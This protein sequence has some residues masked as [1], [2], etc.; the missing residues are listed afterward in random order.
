MSLSGPQASRRC[1]TVVLGSAMTQE[2]TTD[3]NLRPPFSAASY[4]SSGYLNVGRPSARLR[5][6]VTLLA[7]TFQ[8]KFDSLLHVAL[9]FFTVRSGRNAARQVRRVGRK[10]RAGR[11]DDDEILHP[12][13]TFSSRLRTTRSLALFSL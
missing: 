10:T 12:C 2:E 1:L 4:P 7:Q 13:S 5:N 9:D 3:D 8:V 11:F 6:G